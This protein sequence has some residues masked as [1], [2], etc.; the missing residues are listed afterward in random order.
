[1]LFNVVL[2]FLFSGR[3]RNAVYTDGVLMQRASVASR[4]RRNGVAIG[5]YGTSASS[6]AEKKGGKKEE[7]RSSDADRHRCPPKYT[8]SAVPTVAEHG[9]NSYCPAPLRPPPFYDARV[10][11]ARISR[12]RLLQNTLLRTN[13]RVSSF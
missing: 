5:L 3:F 11:P 4:P 1:M 7:T 2:L 8:V 13:D 10:V 12:Y 9:K 6:K